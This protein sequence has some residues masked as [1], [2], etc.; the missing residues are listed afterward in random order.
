MNDKVVNISTIHPLSFGILQFRLA[1]QCLAFV[2][3]IVKA[4]ANRVKLGCNPLTDRL[5]NHL[6]DEAIL[7]KRLSKVALQTMQLLGQGHK[8]HCPRLP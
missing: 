2:S 4:D 1:S 8:S 5:I 6:V 3:V 7:K